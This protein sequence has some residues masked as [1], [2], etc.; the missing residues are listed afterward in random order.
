MSV[1]VY[2]QHF[3]RLSL[4]SFGDILSRTAIKIAS[5]DICYFVLK[6]FLFISDHFVEM[7]A[8]KI[9]RTA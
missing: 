8:A 9:D 5:F 7:G 4:A 1:R 3:L 6:K 2:K